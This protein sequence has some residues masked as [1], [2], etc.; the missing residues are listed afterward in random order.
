MKCESMDIPLTHNNSFN[1]TPDYG[2]KNGTTLFN[3]LWLQFVYLSANA[4]TYL[5]PVYG[6]SRVN[7]I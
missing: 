4:D 3:W 6:C 5:E 2:P 1:K 7:T